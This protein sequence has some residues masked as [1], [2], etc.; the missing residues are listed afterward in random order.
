METLFPGSELV[1]KP[2][3]PFAAVAIEDSL[4][5]L[6]DYS[7][8]KKLA[9]ALRISQR[10]RVPLGRNNRP[11]FGY[12]ISIQ[13]DTTYP[14]VKALLNID[15]DRVLL[16][17]PMMELARWISRYYCAPLGTVIDSVIPSAVK[18]KIGLGYL[19]V[20]RLN[21]PRPEIQE[22]LE[23]TKAPKRRTILARLLQL[24]P[25]HGI[26]IHRLAGESGTTAP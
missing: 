16:A 23:K 15:D 9:A 8:P 13:P 11:T 10:V 1:T 19:Q 12:V 25:D 20:V 26:E 3:G 5:K 7:V 21:K 24:E 14:K 2:I 17:P 22:I 6:L 18:K 4:D